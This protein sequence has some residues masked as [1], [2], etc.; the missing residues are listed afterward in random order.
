MFSGT[1]NIQ[2]TNKCSGLIVLADS[3]LRQLFYNLIHNSIVHGQKVNRIRLYYQ[4]EKNQLKLVYDDNGIQPHEKEKIFEEGYGKGTG[5]GLYLIRKICEA[6]EWT[7][8]ETGVPGKGAK[9]VMTI[10]KTNKKGEI[11]YRFGK[12]QP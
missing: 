6:Y 2:F 7:I 11:A 4:E 9:F 12:H 3:L 10:P 1:Q 5:Y 8:H